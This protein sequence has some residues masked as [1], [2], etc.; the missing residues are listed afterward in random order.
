MK[1]IY[2]SVF[3][4]AIA[5]SSCNQAIEVD[6]PMGK[7]TNT[8]VFDNDDLAQAAMKGIYASMTNALSTAPFQ[9]AMSGP[10]GL[11]SD[12]LDRTSYSDPQQ[13]LLDNN[14]FPNNSSVTG[15]WAAFYNY[16]Y[17]ANVIYEST[18]RSTGMS[19]KVK[20][21]LMGESRFIRALSLFYL[22]NLYGPVPLTVKSDYAVNGL[23]PVSSQQVVYAQIIEDL[24]YAHANIGDDN[25]KAGNRH[26]PSKWAATALL[27]RVYLYQKDWVNAEKEATKLIEQS[28]VYKMETLDNAFL[29][30]STE[31]I[32]NI[33]NAG[34]NIYTGEGSSVGGNATS[35]TVF[36]LT[37]YFVGQFK[38][39]DQRLVKWTKTF[40]GTT[41]PF[42]FKTLSNTQAGAKAESAAPLR[43]AEQYLIRA[44]ARAMQNN[45]NGAIDDIDVIRVR[46]GA[47]ANATKNFQTLRFA[48]PLMTQPELITA[49]YQERMT[50]LFAE[51]G[52]RW[53]DAKRAEPQ[54]LAA[55]FGTR[56]PT[57]SQTDA[58][59]PIPERE[60][61][62]NPNIKQN[63]GY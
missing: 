18:E 10:L 47:V 7:F 62:Y 17:Q 27:A 2:K 6:V 52:H 1:F 53:F 50:E 58:F 37:P 63:D 36:R 51:F 14:L 29:V 16:V 34:A 61:L 55:F 25:I 48:S 45:L 44:E 3:I 59:F 32:W 54:D 49:I 30:A 21:R 57:I 38:S 33:T 5:F 26:R 19:A 13:Q 28:A 60:L 56:K 46:A 23:L 11:S 43:L 41:A 9:G 35:N 8:A 12:E 39:D 31:S 42:K 15:L 40:T 20:A 4:L 22:T 24:N